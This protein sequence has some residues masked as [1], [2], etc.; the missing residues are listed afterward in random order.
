MSLYGM[1]TA[2]ILG[3]L[4]Q[5]SAFSAISQNITN[6]NTG[7]YK[8]FDT[9]FSTVLATT[10][11]QNRDIGGLT[12]DTRNFVEQQGRI[13]SSTSGMDL[14]IA[15]KGMYVLN[16][17]V[18]GSGD[19]LYTRDGGFEIKADAEITDSNGNTI[20][21]GYIVDKNGYY[22]QGW[23]A[24]GSGTVTTSSALQSLRVDSEA[25]NSGGAADADAT[26]SASI[27]VNLP[28]TTAVGGTQTTNASVFDADGDTQSF[29]LTWTKNATNQEWTL[30]VTPEGG[31]ASTVT[32]M[33]FDSSGGLPDGTTATVAFTGSDS[34]AVSFTLDISDVSSI[35]S[36][37]LYFDF[38]ND[39]RTSG[40]LDSFKFDTAG[41][42]IGRFSNGLE[43][44]LYKLPLAIFTNAD[45]L[46]NLQGN[47]FQ[48]S[49]S[50]G[51]AA[52][53]EVRAENATSDIFHEFA[54]FVPFS[55]ELSNTNLQNEFTHMIMSQQAYNSAATVFKSV[56]EMT[57]Q[58]AN[59]KT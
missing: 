4:A 41:K 36:E 35:G 57:Q 27:A 59:L 42:V 10:Y 54:H 2:P 1:F 15:G 11:S 13:I 50:S 25:F 20:N 40:E 3:M 45:G 8:A 46:D 37:F 16:T 18:D 44:T 55:H 7:G 53:I 43:Q 51:V 49:V 47:L 56:D 28:A 21:E 29:E 30:S 58:A 26:A 32:T 14:A 34:S 5:T 19:Q 48:E 24:D 23:A 17:E 22:L 31:S 38:Q 9:R 39:G 6:M 33:T 12:A 52:L